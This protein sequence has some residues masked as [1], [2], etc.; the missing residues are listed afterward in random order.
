MEVVGF[1]PRFVVMFDWCM[2]ILRLTLLCSL[3]ARPGG[4]CAA[5]GRPELPPELPGLYWESR[6]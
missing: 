1:L 3:A 5:A 4:F 2:L 6:D